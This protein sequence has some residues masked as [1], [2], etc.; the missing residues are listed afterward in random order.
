MGLLKTENSTGRNFVFIFY[1]V[2]DSPLRSADDAIAVVHSQSD[3]DKFSNLQDLWETLDSAANPEPS[4][5]WLFVET[6]L[7][8]GTNLFLANVVKSVLT[9]WTVLGSTVSFMIAFTFPGAFFYTIR[10]KRKTRCRNRLA[11]TLSSVSVILVFV[12]T[13]QCIAHIND[14]A[15]PKQPTQADLDLTGQC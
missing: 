11:L 14:P 12:C 10:K 5:S 1:I 3:L 9:L 8:I 13:W 6:T 4:T 7:M 2:K 15:C